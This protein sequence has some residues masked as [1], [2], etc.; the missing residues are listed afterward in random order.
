MGWLVVAL[1]VVLV[2]EGLTREQSLQQAQAR[3]EERV[4]QKIRDNEARMG[5]A[6]TKEK[7]FIDSGSTVR[8]KR[9]KQ[10]LFLFPLY[11]LM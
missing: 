10:N 3:M 1:C 5:S 6:Y 2:A 8:K 11:A 4:K 7:R 9:E